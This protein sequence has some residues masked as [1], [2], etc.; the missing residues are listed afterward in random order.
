MH[1]LWEQERRLWLD[2]QEAYEELLSDEV[3]MTFPA[4]GG[5]LD[6]ATVID[7]LDDSNRWEAVAFDD[8][9]VRELGEDRLLI[10]TAEG[11]REGE[12]YAAGCASVWRLEG[13]KYRL[14]YHQQTPV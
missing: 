12:G 11:R 4:P 8:Q 14:Y 7:S 2:G 3:L 5:P 9:H 1:D 10:Y 13:D 6:R